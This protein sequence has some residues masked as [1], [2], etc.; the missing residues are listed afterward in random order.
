[1]IST[2]QVSQENSDFHKHMLSAKNSVKVLTFTLE[3]ITF[4]LN[5]TLHCFLAVHC[6]ETEI[7]H[8]LY[9]RKSYFF[10]RFGVDGHP[11]VLKALC[12]AKERLKPGKSFLE[13]V[14]H[15]VFT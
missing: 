14:L 15:V 9:S 12:E 3:Q 5:P 10:A 13:D 8:V 11:C 4:Y 6:E 2:H 1:M 7:Q